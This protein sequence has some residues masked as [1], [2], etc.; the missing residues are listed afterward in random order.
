[1]MNR[2]FAK[3]AIVDDVLWESIRHHRE[4]YTSVRDVDY[5]PDVRKRLQLVPRKDILDAWK[6]DYEAMKEAMIYGSKPSFEE[7]L[8]AMSELQEKF[9]IRH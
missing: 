1:M 7:L 2:D 3:E 8:E 6:D 5:T 9:R 4:I